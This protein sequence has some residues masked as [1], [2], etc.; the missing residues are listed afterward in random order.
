MKLFMKI[1]SIKA[2]L[3]RISAKLSQQGVLSLPPCIGQQKATEAPW[4]D[5]ADM[6]PVIEPECDML[7]ALRLIGPALC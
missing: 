1:G 5:K 4:V 3:K 6:C 7:M 2:G